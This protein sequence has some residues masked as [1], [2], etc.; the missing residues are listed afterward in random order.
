MYAF[1]HDTRK[2]KVSAVLLL[3][4][5]AGVMHGAQADAPLAD[6][7]LANAPLAYAP[8]AYASLADARESDM[9]IQP[10]L[11]LRITLL[12]SGNQSHSTVTK[13]EASCSEV[14]SGL[15]WSD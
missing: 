7:P 10:R 14:W 13:R 8:L 4:F 6:A 15:V 3:P 2:C 11:A 9:S 12:Y 5:M 1:H